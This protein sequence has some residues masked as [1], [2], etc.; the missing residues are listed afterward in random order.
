MKV[1]TILVLDLLTSQQPVGQGNV[2]ELEDWK[3][4][5]LGLSTGTVDY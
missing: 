2:K 3:A 5:I 1:K 4:E